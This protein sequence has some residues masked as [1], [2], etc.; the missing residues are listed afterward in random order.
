MDWRWVLA[1]L[2]MAASVSGGAKAHARQTLL[3]EDGHASRALRPGRLEALL[4]AGIVAKPVRPAVSQNSTPVAPRPVAEI[5]FSRLTPD[6]VLPLELETGSVATPDSVWIPQRQSKAIVRVDPKTN[7][8]DTPLDVP[9]APCASLAVAFDTVW[10]PLCE[11]ASI[12]R[13]STKDGNVSAAVPLPVAT[14]EGSVA[15]AVGSLWVLTEA[16]G[17]LSRIDPDTNAAV[18]EAYIAAKPSAVVAT[19]DALWVTSEDGDVVTRVD[20]HTNLIVATINVGPRPGRVVAGEG[21]VWT[22]NRGDGSVSRID[23]KSNKVVATIAVGDAIVGGDMAVG[24]G[25]VWLSARGTPIIRI[26]PASN[27]VAQRFTGPGG[28]AIVVGHGSLWVAAGPKLTWR[29]D[30]KLVAALR[31]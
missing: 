29:I 27:R 24:E 18:A 15:S 19:D 5:P 8:P 14:P 21:A 1:A 17:V 30:Q 3:A 31:P 26:D 7:K 12:A 20:P 9:G 16:K 23:P 2:A 10:V 13:V 28:G 22:L 4:A 11:G 6:T 25:S